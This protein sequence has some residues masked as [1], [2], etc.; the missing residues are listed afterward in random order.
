MKLIGWEPRRRPLEG[1]AGSRSEVAGVS[2]GEG[3][4]YAFNMVAAMKTDRLGYFTG[5]MQCLTTMLKFGCW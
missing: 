1:G 3:R 4:E 5:V 2:V